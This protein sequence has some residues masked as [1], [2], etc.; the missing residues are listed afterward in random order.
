MRLT[1]GFINP[2]NNPETEVLGD[3]GF[4]PRGARSA[5]HLVFRKTAHPLT[6]TQRASIRARKIHSGFVEKGRLY[7]GAAPTVSSS[8]VTMPIADTHAQGLF[9]YV[10]RNKGRNALVKRGAV[11]P[12]R[13]NEQTGILGDLGISTVTVKYGKQIGLPGW[14]APYRSLGSRFKKSAVQAAIMAGGAFLGAKALNRA[15]GSTT[16]TTAPAGTTTTRAGTGTG[17][18]SQVISKVPTRTAGTTPS[19]RTLPAS[20]APTAFPG[21][22]GGGG[23]LPA[24][25]VPSEDQP[26]DPATDLFN[27]DD[28][29]NIVTPVTKAG[30][31]GGGGMGGVLLVAGLLAAVMMGGGKKRRRG[32]R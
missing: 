14:K 20:A 5:G 8:A 23:F 17:I 27:V 32:R 24:G 11:V 12:V 3:L 1:R 22:G 9:A 16:S 6:A 18:L 15:P 30:V 13:A 26:F 31:A 25:P 10:Q 19:S 29:G 7:R 4:N 2:T 21:G 28:Q